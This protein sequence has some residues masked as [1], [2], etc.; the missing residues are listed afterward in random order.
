M[1]VTQQTGTTTPQKKP[2]SN[3]SP[4]GS[5]SGLAC[6]PLPC[7]NAPGPTDSSSISN[8]TIVQGPLHTRSLEGKDAGHHRSFS[9]LISSMYSSKQSSQSSE[10]RF[11][12]LFHH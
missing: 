4:S 8:L 2:S 11:G 10:S 6:S 9:A 1:V 7:W 5:I 12:S 3:S